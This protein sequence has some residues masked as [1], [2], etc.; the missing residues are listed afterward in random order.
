MIGK[1]T[2]QHL[3]EEEE[4]AEESETRYRL[5]NKDDERETP[6]IRV[7]DVVR[8]VKVVSRPANPLLLLEKVLKVEPA[9]RE[10]LLA[11]LWSV[12][13]DTG[14]ATFHLVVGKDWWKEST[15]AVVYPIDVQYD[16]MQHLYHLRTDPLDIHQIVMGP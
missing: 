3:G 2:L 10:V 7:G 5:E 16:K 11:H 12:T 13:D 4:V 14:G 6:T 8:V 1:K 9:T 15:V